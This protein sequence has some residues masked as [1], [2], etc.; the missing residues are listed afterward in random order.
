[1]LDSWQTSQIILRL[2][3]GDIEHIRHHSETVSRV[4]LDLAKLCSYDC[5]REVE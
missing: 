2:Q 5:G 3:L 4:C 1:L